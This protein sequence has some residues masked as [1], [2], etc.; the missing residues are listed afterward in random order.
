MRGGMRGGDPVMRASML[1]KQLGL[2][3]EVTTQVKAIFTDGSAKMQALRDDPSS[4]ADKRSQMM[5]IRQA[6]STKVNALLTPDQQKKYA[7]ME[8]RMRQRGPGGPP[9]PP[10][11]ATP[12]PPPQQ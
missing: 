9:P 3:D 8:E 11:G 6:E 4:P 5:S 10:D 7:E 1:Q 12:P 2:T